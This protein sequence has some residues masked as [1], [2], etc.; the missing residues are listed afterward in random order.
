M[1]FLDADGERPARG[2]GAMGLQR[3]WLT[4]FDG[5]L[6]ADHLVAIPIKC[7]SPTETFSSCWAPH[8]LCLPIYRE[9]RGVKALLLFRLPL[10]IGSGRCD[11]IDPILLAALHKLFGFGVIRVG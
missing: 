2:C 6:D 3:A 7:G 11:Q 10:V 1:V 4:I 8:F 9:T 5:K